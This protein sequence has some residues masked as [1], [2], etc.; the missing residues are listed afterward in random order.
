[1]KDIVDKFTSIRI[2]N[3]T[4]ILIVISLLV[5]LGMIVGSKEQIIKQGKQIQQLE[6]AL[7]LYK[8]ETK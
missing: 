1:M 8:E 5:L 6:A 4:P 2:D 3:F 7:S